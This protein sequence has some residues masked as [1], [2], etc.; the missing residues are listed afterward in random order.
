[1]RNFLILLSLSLLTIVSCTDLNE[2]HQ[3]YLD[4]GETIYTEKPSALTSF[5]GHERVGLAW[6]MLSDV[7]VTGARIYWNNGQDST[8]VAFTVTSGVLD[9]IAAII[10]NIDEGSYIFNVKTMDDYGNMSVP[11]Q[12]AGT[13]Y[14]DLYIAGILSNNRGIASYELE[15]DTLVFTMETVDYDDYFDSELKYT[16]NSGNEQTTV[17]TDEAK[18]EFEISLDDIDI[19]QP[20]YYRSIYRPEDAIDVFY[21]D[22]EL[23]DEEIN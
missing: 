16:N 2:M 20:I 3:P 7:S 17:L 23:Y 21:T 6:I 12:V 1:M 14:G 22:Y 19:T 8:D 18:T 15:T 13:A 10:P 5:P 4:R 11:V 9:T